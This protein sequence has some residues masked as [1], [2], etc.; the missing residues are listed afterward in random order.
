LP[1]DEIDRTRYRYDDV[2]TCVL[3][4]VPSTGEYKVFRIHGVVEPTFDVATLGGDQRWKVRPR[5]PTCYCV[6][7]PIP[8]YRAAVVSGVVYFLLLHGSRTGT[9]CS[10]GS[11][12]LATEQ[13]R[14]TAIEGPPGDG[15]ETGSYLGLRELNGCLVGAC[16]TYKTRATELW[17]LEDE[18]TRLWTKRY[19][20]PWFG[21]FHLVAVSYDKRI[22]VWA[23]TGRSSQ[24]I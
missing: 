8:Q 6:Q 14:P 5:P 22:V 21:L 4:R 10:V 13:W 24:S 19:S 9:P 12:D 7:Y 2:S 17:F 23:K 3:G 20:L 1:G 18:A 11:F 15:S 16:R